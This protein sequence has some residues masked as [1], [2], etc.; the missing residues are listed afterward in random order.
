MTPYTLSND[1]DKIIKVYLLKPIKERK[2]TDWSLNEFAELKKNIK[3]H[4]IKEQTRTCA[5][6]KVELK[7]EHN[8]LWDLEHIIDRNSN[9]NFMFEP[10]NLCVSCKDCNT[11]KG[12]TNVLKNKGRKTFPNESS[13]YLIIHPHFDDYAEHITVVCPG[14]L[15]RPRTEKGRFTI[16]TC[17]LLRFFSLAGMDPVDQN[18]DELAKVLIGSQGYARK[19]ISE[20]LVEKI[21]ENRE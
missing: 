19:L 8:A 7:T 12:T 20:K 4:Y 16:I 14:D 6:C 9:V 15:Y 13:D 18:I 11:Y 1:E 10:K 17:N 5:Y 2:N 3:N 21:T